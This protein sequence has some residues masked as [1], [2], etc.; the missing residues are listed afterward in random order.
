MTIA[1]GTDALKL[2][3]IIYGNKT[4]SSQFDTKNQVRIVRE[5]A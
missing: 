5:R 3:R 1:S 4:F 2:L